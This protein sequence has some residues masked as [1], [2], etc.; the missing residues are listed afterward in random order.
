MAKPRLP[1]VSWRGRSIPPPPLA[2]WRESR[3]KSGEAK[4]C[5][6]PQDRDNALRG[7]AAELRR[8]PTERTGPDPHAGHGLNR[9]GGRVELDAWFRC[10]A[11][12]ATRRTE[13]RHERCAAPLPACG[14]RGGRDRFMARQARSR[15]AGGMLATDTSQ[16]IVGYVPRGRACA[17]RMPGFPAEG[18][19]PAEEP[20]DHCPVQTS[21]LTMWIGPPIACPRVRS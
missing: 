5:G 13:E 9:P 2:R 14:H 11:P 19:G 10:A 4:P 7:T 6:Q 15:R 1:R 17:G 20:R 3:D 16:R 18:P 8:R 12:M 21:G